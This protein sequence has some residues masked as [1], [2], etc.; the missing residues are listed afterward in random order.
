MTVFHT[1]NDARASIEN[2]HARDADRDGVESTS[3]G[4]TSQQER[5]KVLVCITFVLELIILAGI[6]VLEYFLRWTE[7]F[8][9]RK[10][11]FTCTDPGLS[12]SEA[13]PAFA[14]FTFRAVIPTEVVYSLSLCVPP[15]VMLI[16]E[17]AV[18]AFTEDNQKSVRVCCNPCNVPQ[19]FRRLVRFVGVFVFGLVS[20]MVF[21]DVVKLLTG[22]L[23]PNFL[24]VCRLNTTRCLLNGN[25]GG[26][27]LCTNANRIELRH[28]RGS[29]PS[30]R[31]TMTAYAA[32]FISIYIH[33]A[34][35]TRSVRVLRPFL[36]LVFLML[37]L[38]CGLAEIG[39]N[40]NAWIDVVVGWGT[41]IAMAMYLGAF[42]L[43]NFR[44]YVS[45]RKMIRLLHGFLVDHQLLNEITKD[46]K[47]RLFPFPFHI[48]RAHTRPASPYAQKFDGIKPQATPLAVYDDTGAGPSTDKYHDRPMPSP[49]YHDNQRMSHL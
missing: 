37:S 43:Y 16:G 30:M 21:V 9:M 28:A 13:D 48:P 49:G 12:H 17:V 3:S 22:Q 31:A 26:D 23:R 27:E 24:E 29:F 47:L 15:F 11:N 40:H 44:E 5:G 38:L 2:L 1:G 42:V 7:A 45:E 33:G 6:I 32:V 20:V 41:G 34:L 4:Y 19:F 46:G 36:S 39:L 18:W 35:R 10:V 14:S 25:V 8:P